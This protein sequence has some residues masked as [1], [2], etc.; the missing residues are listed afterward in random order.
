MSHVL[1]KNVVTPTGGDIVDDVNDA[2]RVNV[3]AGGGAG[4]GTSSAF[5]APFPASG[6]AAGAKDSGGNMAALN[7]DA[8][9][10]LLVASSGG[11]AGQQYADGVTRGTATGT[12]AMGDDGTNI[13]SIR[14]DS[15]GVL[16]IQD[17]GASLTIDG[18][19]AVSNAFLLDATFTGRINTQGQKTSALSTPIVIASDQS[20]FPVTANA[21][22]NLN[23]SLLALE[24]G[25]LATLSAKDFATQATLAL[26][27]AKTDNIPA[28]PSREGG[29]L[30]TAAKQDTGNASLASIDTKLTAPITITG[31]VTASSAATATAAEPNYTEG[32]ASA[33]SQDLTGHLRTKIHALVNDAVQAYV[34]NTVQPLSM[35]NDGRLRVSSVPARTGISFLNPGEGV[36]WGDLEPVWSFTG[37][38]WQEW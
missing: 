22:T 8:S 11:S 10:N 33:F 9:G 15:S 30:A 13:Q 16:A 23:T 19:V 3:V 25:N 26:I 14:V 1:I 5:G 24:S 2:L 27:K 4:G 34:D 35:T 38:P 31:T 20:A 6:T 37:S 12:L 7:L 18:T 29:V 28:D 36:M 17:N 32:T 21:G